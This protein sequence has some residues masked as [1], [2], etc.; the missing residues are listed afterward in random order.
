MSFS[1]IPNLR[2]V[3]ENV[4]NVPSITLER[5]LRENATGGIK[6]Y[7]RR[8]LVPDGVINFF[9]MVIM[10]R[11]REGLLICNSPSERRKLLKDAA[12][13]KSYVVVEN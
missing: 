13:Y 11:I 7:G 6:R 9:R 10:D 1:S 8:S 5:I 12:R 3:V 4:E 2:S